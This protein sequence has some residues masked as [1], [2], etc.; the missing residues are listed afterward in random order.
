MKREILNAILLEGK[1]ANELLSR[2]EPGQH[3]DAAD[4]E[5]L[6]A[7]V[8]KLYRH[9]CVYSFALKN[10]DRATDLDVHLHI[11]QA[12]FE[13]E[14]KTPPRDV[15]PDEEVAPPLLEV[16]PENVMKEQLILKIIEFGLNDKFRFANELFGG[17]QSEFQAALHQLNSISS[18]I[19]MDVYLES[20]K[21]IYLWKENLP[22]TRSFYASVY[23]R[24]E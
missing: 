1:K 22:I 17:S 3:L 24:F 9:L 6:L 8:E 4:A 14:S 2:I 12:I 23:R 18:K 20:L 11:M 5:E 13:K 19:E 10:K 16:Q 21:E 15:E 7:Q